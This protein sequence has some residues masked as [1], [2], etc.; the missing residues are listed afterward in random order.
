MTEARGSHWQRLGRWL[1]RLLIALVLVLGALL[2][3]GQ[4]LIPLAAHYPQRVAGFLSARLQAPVTVG[5]MQGRWHVSGPSLNLQNVRIG[6]R[7]KPPLILPSVRVKF[8]PGAWFWPSRHA[9][10]LHL[11]GV[12]LTLARGAHGK[13]H[14][15]GFGAD[16]SQ[17]S[18]TGRLPALAGTLWLD[19]L[20]LTVRDGETGHVYHL[21]AD[22]VRVSSNGS[23]WRF[24]G[25]VHRDGVDARLRFVGRVRNNARTGRLWLAARNADL[26][27]MLA[28]TDLNGYAVTAG[29]G[30]VG[31][32]LGWDNQRLTDAT[33]S[34]DLRDVRVRGERGKASVPALHGLIRYRKRA[35]NAQV[36]AAI[37]KQGLMRVDV[38]GIGTDALRVTAGARN[39]VARGWPALAGFLPGMPE[40]TGHWLLDS[41]PRMHLSRARVRW[42][43]R[44]GLQRL[45]ARFD[46]LALDAHGQVPG[47]DSLRGRVQGDGEGL[48]LTLPGQ[49]VSIAYP[50][51]FRQ[52]LDWSQLAGN[53]VAW[54]E[55]GS[56]HVATDG[57]RLANDDMALSANGRIRIPENGGKPTV[58]MRGQLDHLSLQQVPG[59]LPTGT[60]NP[61]A[62]KWLE[63]GF[64]DGTL[65]DG[66]AVLRG[67][68][69]DWPFADHE[70]RFEARGKVNDATVAF[71]PQWPHARHITADPVF[72]DD[73]MH[74]AGARGDVAGVHAR[75]ATIH[76]SHFS[77]PEL[78]LTAH[79][80]GK[81]AD[82]LAL[83][84]D[85]PISKDQAEVM[86]ALQLQGDGDVDLSLLVPLSRK[87][88]RPPSV[89]GEA[90]FHGAD[91]AAS[92]WGVHLTDL[93]GTLGFTRN[94]VRASQ[95]RAVLDD[96]PVDLSLAIG[97][98]PGH[99]DWKLSAGL[100]GQLSVADLVAGRE[101]LKPL[102]QVGHGTADIDVG[103]HVDPEADNAVKRQRVLTLQS[104][105]QGIALDLPAPL[106]KQ[107]DT[108]LPLD[109]HVGLPAEDLLVAGSLGER[110]RVR[111]RLPHAADTAPVADIRL[112]GNAP[113]DTLPDSGIHIRG[114]ADTLDLS[115][116]GS[117]LLKNVPDTQGVRPDVDADVAVDT[118]RL[119][120]AELNDLEI[121]L[122]TADDRADL[123]A[124]GPAVS[125]HL[126][127]PL[128]Q[129][130][131]RGVVA[132]FDRLYWPRARVGHAQPAA[133]ASPPP[134]PSPAEAADVGVAPDSLPPLHL[135]IGDLRLGDAH[136]GKARLEARPIDNGVRIALLRTQS[137]QVN[138][139]AQGSWTGTAHDSQTSMDIDFRADNLGH[140]LNAFGYRD[141]I[142][143]G[144][145]HAEL[146]ASWPGAPSS[147]VLANLNG[148]LD[149]DVGSGSIPE[150]EPGMGRLLGLMSIT[151][152]P[153]RLT[154]DFG[155]VFGGGFSFDS[156]IG[157]FRFANGSA[158]TDDF[159]VK[160]ASADMSLQGRVGL[161]AHDYNQK[162]VAVPH[163][164][165]SLPVVG[166]VLGGPIGIAAG[167]A[168]QGMLGH[169]LNTAASA[170]YHITGSWDDPD[171]ERVDKDAASDEMAVP[172]APPTS[173]D[174]PAE[175]SSV[176]DRAATPGAQ[177]DGRAHSESAPLQ[178]PEPATS[179]GSVLRVPA[180][181]V[182]DSDSAAN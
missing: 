81:L 146:N 38:S 120:D 158:Y 126:E 93:T 8:D 55:D 173:S 56:W 79:A 41:R 142:D 36:L 107:A 174:A 14:L 75:N 152:I 32:W 124:Q 69:A 3:A 179:V 40:A 154:L 89:S 175:A 128:G 139:D 169:G 131:E 163:V 18:G 2:L 149:V 43:R 19:D 51:M 63:H 85:S 99:P 103:F 1:R 102:G 164:G 108:M 49:A 166:G 77:R 57:L 17:R 58:A 60:M 130:D 180:S 47:V 50:H 35:E 4:L 101:A 114:K 23:T 13:W 9:V 127:V 117:W 24:A 129:A 111:A 59:Y 87:I 178:V 141:L 15:R 72:I 155:D 44:H 171:I 105:L 112:G 95:L 165:N 181:V 29:Q 153:R 96:K 160:G 6:G 135:R 156:I 70:G 42:S 34:M 37:G 30:D 84:S 65:D 74:V 125:G 76:I 52:P 54:P 113:A 144:K 92:D 20:A 118:A 162:V 73:G 21:R 100:S 66:R 123:S 53:V 46:H 98:V 12:H 68:M 16:G 28:D 48:V 110:A 148:R 88:D 170:H 134:P 167:L 145:T 26:G 121:T 78:A 104:D 143:G 137:K 61:S 71:D 147:F 150:V 132:Q 177:R 122:H 39:M 172:T 62:V 168:M 94:R 97:S 161:R 106:H 151:E 67:D 22:P 10:N 119:F 27:A 83:V 176:H 80:G 45:N 116:W 64:L 25:R 31:L 159:K 91:F 140:M 11:Q 182:P 157:T 7:D 136:L 115:G 133:G 138:I 90:R 33:A 109:L 5:S 86:Q 82:M